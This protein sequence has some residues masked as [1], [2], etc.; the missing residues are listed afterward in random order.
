MAYENLR[1]MVAGLSNDIYLGTMMKNEKMPVMN[2][3]RRVF[4][5]QVIRA[6]AEHMMGLEEGQCYEF[7]GH[8]KLMWE[9]EK[10]QA[11]GTTES[12]S[13]EGTAA[14]KG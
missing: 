12:P 14:D 3:K 10:P 4:T 1:L 5:N 7:P 6:C 8:G 11:P 2:A 9:R 13:P